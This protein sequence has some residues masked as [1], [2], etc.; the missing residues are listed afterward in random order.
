VLPSGG[1]RDKG[2]GTVVEARDVAIGALE[3]R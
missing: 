3:A 1:L 2:G